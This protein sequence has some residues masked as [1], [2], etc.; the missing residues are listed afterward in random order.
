VTARIVTT[1]VA[2]IDAHKARDW[3]RDN[4]PAA[5]SLFEDELTEAL[6]LLVEQPNAGKPAPR[7]DYPKLR[8][9]VMRRTRYLIFYEYNAESGEV[10]VR[11]IWSALR[12][13]PPRLGRR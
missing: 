5:P 6:A 4:R 13:R 9:L 8:R 12:G 10:L 1:R 2:E 7:P 11:R 3:W